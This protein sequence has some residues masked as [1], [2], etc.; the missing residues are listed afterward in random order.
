[1]LKPVAAIFASRLQLSIEIREN[2]GSDAPYNPGRIMRSEMIFRAKV[3]I[4]NKYQLCQTA[5]K[6]TRRLHVS[7]S[8]TQ[9]TIHNAFVRIAT[10]PA[11][12]VERTDGTR[13]AAADLRSDRIAKNSGLI[14]S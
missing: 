6:A 5:A 10:G 1:M 13:G 7:S 14:T 2:I 11:T 3:S 12:P 8:D 9:M 4:E